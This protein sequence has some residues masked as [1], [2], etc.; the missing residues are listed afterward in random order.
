LNG[1]YLDDLFHGYTHY[2][3]TFNAFGNAFLVIEGVN[4]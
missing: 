2:D 1:Q 4:T 3:A